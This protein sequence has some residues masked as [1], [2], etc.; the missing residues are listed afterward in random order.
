MSYSLNKFNSLA[1]IY[2]TLARAV[3]GKSIRNAQVYY[4]KEIPQGCNV[5]ILG[6]GTGWII[7]ELFL[8][9]PD[10][11]IWYIEASTAMIQRSQ[12]RV[13]EFQEAC[14]HFIHG[15][16]DSI[17]AGIKYGAVITPFFL[18]LFSATTLSHVVR[19]IRS[20]LNTDALWL[21]T[22]FVNRHKWWQRAALR[23]MYF[24][25]RVVCRIESEELPAWENVLSE[26]GCQELKSNYFF[27]SFIKATVFGMRLVDD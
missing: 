4:L 26:S 27:G 25:F 9:N 10:V 13:K 24:F 3:F 23:F 22:D 2:D 7:R 15:T 17:P 21:A 6:G 19:K 16:E 12:K 5:L 8:V 14:V 1:W 11:H 20:S 18:D